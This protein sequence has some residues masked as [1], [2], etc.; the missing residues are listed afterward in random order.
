MA[1]AKAL[2]IKPEQVEVMRG[3][4]MAEP[5]PHKMAAGVVADSPKARRPLGTTPDAAVALHLASAL[6]DGSRQF[7]LVCASFRDG[8][9]LFSAAL[10]KRRLEG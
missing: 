7:C 2:A 3:G 9:A 10:T 6:R 5:F 1:R 8:T 4:T